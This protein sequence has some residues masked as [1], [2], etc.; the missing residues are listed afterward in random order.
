MNTQLAST[1]GVTGSKRGLR[2]AA[3]AAMLYLIAGTYK[4]ALNHVVRR[5]HSNRQVRFLEIGPGYHRIPGF[6]TI[7]IMWTP[8]TDYVCDAARPLPFGDATFDLIY[9][10]HVLEHIPWYQVPH[11][12]REW[13]R[14]LKDD[15]ALEVWVPDGLKICR[16]FVDAEDRGSCDF[17][18]DGWYPFNN[19]RDP[20]IWAAGRM[21]SY[22]DGNGTRG[23]PN[24]HMALFYE[25]RL[26]ELLE[27]SG[28]TRVR[29]LSSG[30]I[31][32]YDH[33]WINLGLRGEC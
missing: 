32:G 27:G 31:R 21:F 33:G 19:G 20:A 4:V 10:S 1:I 7:N 29:R 18:G 30:E 11:A 15:G 16:A 9:A 28:F 25:R 23:H 8:V 13:R 2:T 14:I 24:W 5:R 17:E 3:K 12:V 26:R 6:E 22:G